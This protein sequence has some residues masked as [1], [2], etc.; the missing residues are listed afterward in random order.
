LAAG[1][2]APRNPR[3]GTPSANIKTAFPPVVL[4]GVV[5]LLLIANTLNIAADIAAM[6]ETAELVT[7]FDRHGMTVFFVVV[8][9]LLQ[10]FVP[11]HRYVFFLKWLMLSLLAYAAVLFTVHVP[12]GEV[13]CA[14]AG[15]GRRPI[16]PRV[17]IMSRICVTVR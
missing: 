11:Y 6:G 17:R 12:W 15:A 16:A 8:T 14:P 4:R 3:I 13:A 5:L 10:V 1:C 9:V 2:I 7:G